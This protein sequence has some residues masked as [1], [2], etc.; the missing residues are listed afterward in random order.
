MYL[1]MTLLRVFRE[2]LTNIVK[3]AAASDVIAQL[4]VTAGEVVFSVCDNGVG[5]GDKHAKGRGVGNM[6]TRVGDIGGTFTIGSESGTC[7]RLQIPLPLQFPSDGES[8]AE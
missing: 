2:S 4:C 7:I 8:H 3:H 1:Y 6:R 5:L